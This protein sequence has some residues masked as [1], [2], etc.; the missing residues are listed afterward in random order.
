MTT[1]LKLCYLDEAGNSGDNLHD[2]QQPFFVLGGLIVVSSKW[3]EVNRDAKDVIQV[4]G[5]YRRGDPGGAGDQRCC[6]RALGEALA[7]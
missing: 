6:L 3:R 1:E 4:C 7:A 2:R 5:A